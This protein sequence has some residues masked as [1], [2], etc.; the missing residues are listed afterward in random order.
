MNINVHF[1]NVK[2]L[3]VTRIK[4][5]KNVFTS[6]GIGHDHSSPGIE[7]NVI[8]Q[9]QGQRSMQNACDGNSRI[10]TATPYEYWSMAVNSTFPVWR[11]QL[12]ASAAQRAAWRRRD[13]RM[14][15][16]LPLY[17]IR[18]TCVENWLGIHRPSFAA[19]SCD[20]VA[21]QSCSRR[22]SSR[23]VNRPLH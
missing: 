9:A 18:H 15:E 4:M 6:A 7:S 3:N 1:S 14:C 5:Q 22:L 2:T 21:G 20:S 19:A 17:S 12:R 10:F 13:Q 8:G 23:A 11:H 16:Y